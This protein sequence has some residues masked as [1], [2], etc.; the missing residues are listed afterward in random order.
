MLA[1]RLFIVVSCV[2]FSGVLSSCT[3]KGPDSSASVPEP[4][5]VDSDKVLAY[6]AIPSV[7]RVLRDVI[8]FADVVQPGAVNEKMLTAQIGAMVG[9][10]ELATLHRDKPLVVLVLKGATPGA[11]AVPPVVAFLPVKDGSPIEQAVSA[12]GM[13]TKRS[14]GVLLVA[15]T[16]EALAAAE[17][18]R[19]VYDKIASAK[20]Q[21]TARLYLHTGRVLDAYRAPLDAQIAALSGMAGMFGPPAE[22]GGLSIATILKAEVN[23]LLAVLSQCR[24]TQVS[25]GLGKDGVTLDTVLVAK[26]SSSMAKFFSGSSQQRGRVLAGGAPGVAEFVCSIDAKAL[27]ASA[28][29]I[30]RELSKDPELG[31]IL[32]PEFT[33]MWTGMGDW[34]S[35]T[36]DVQYGF[37]DE[38]L[39]YHAVMGVTDESKLIDVLRQSVGMFG[40]GGAL[41][42]MYKSLGMDLSASVE[43]TTREHAGVSIHE[44]AMTWNMGG[45]DTETAEVFKMMPS[46]W[47][48]AVVDGTGLISTDRDGIDLMI[49]D[50]KAGRASSRTLEATR[51]FGDGQQVYMDLNIQELMKSISQIAGPD[52]GMKFLAQ[53][54]AGSPSVSMAVS[55]EDNRMRCQARV[56]SA[57]I[58]MFALIGSRSE[59]RMPTPTAR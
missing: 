37:S 42:G 10:P 26:P 32:T 38:G 54:D 40:Q 34:W 4:L 35:G 25:V 6:V 31:A 28:D 17:K 24:E 50:A 49:D 51:V 2:I 27:A 58:Q 29:E 56:P 48:L 14:G 16:S 43:A 18:M 13:Q 22:P 9:D 19:A 3:S 12:L 11:A 41:Q 55:F 39:S 53:S 36:A 1:H 33:D 30:V 46:G 45:L 52:A 20:T 8:A 59:S 44:W 23:G 21:D 57:Q 5:A 47:S 15:Q 7:D